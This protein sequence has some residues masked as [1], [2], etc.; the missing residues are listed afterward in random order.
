MVPTGLLAL[1]AP[2]L[3]G[4]EF[5]RPAP[6]RFVGNHDPTLKQDLFDEL[7]AERKSEIEPDRVRNDLRR[8]AVALVDD[9]RR[10]HGSELQDR[11]LRAGYRDNATA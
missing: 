5:D 10:A 8:K 6:A 11:R 2:G 1:Q 9:G 4:S 7:Q 3:I